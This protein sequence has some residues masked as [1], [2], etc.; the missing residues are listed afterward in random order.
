MEMMT[1]LD[2]S[3]LSS[4]EF[5]MSGRMC[6]VCETICRVILMEVHI[7]EKPDRSLL[8]VRQTSKWS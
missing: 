4:Q 6:C 1:C 3:Q 2:K 5:Q 8:I 7:P